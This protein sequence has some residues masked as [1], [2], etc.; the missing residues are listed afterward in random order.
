M[1]EFSERA[2]I[3]YSNF[4][5]VGNCDTRVTHEQCGTL[6]DMQIQHNLKGSLC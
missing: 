4:L 1:K 3:T 6:N 2:T 5:K